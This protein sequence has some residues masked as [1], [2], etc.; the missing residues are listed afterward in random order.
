M[1]ISEITYN[2]DI[3]KFLDCSKVGDEIS[4]L[5][6]TIQSIKTNLIDQLS[7]CTLI[8][9]GGLDPKSFSLG[10]E[11]I[12][13]N[14]AIECKN[15]FDSILE[16]CTKLK[17]KILDNAISHRKMELTKFISCIEERID[18]VEVLKNNIVKK[19]EKVSQKEIFDTSLI[20]VAKLYVHKGNYEKELNELY[21][22]L[23]WAKK[24]LGKV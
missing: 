8:E 22:K 24:E 14:R 3:S 11:A 18:N 1:K 13:T 10:G 7:N 5:E 4:E 17:T 2:T 16:S 15:S 19:I 21:R 12:L 6:T 23:D 20:E 9:N